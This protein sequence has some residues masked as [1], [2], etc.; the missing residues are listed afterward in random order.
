M[1]A[2]IAE[3]EHDLGKDHTAHYG[4]TH[5]DEHHDKGHKKAAGKKHEKHEKEEHKADHHEEEHHDTSAKKK[6]LKRKGTMA[7]VIEETEHD[8][9][10]NH[11]KK[12]GGRRASTS[13][14]KSAGRGRS[15][16]AKGHK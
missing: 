6:V 13:K 5:A 11:A 9:G 1:A 14:G 2:V 10:K 3:T 12:F 4:L 16:S 7:S 8:L 15:K